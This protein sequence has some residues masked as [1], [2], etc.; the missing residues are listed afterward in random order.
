MWIL[1]IVILLGII[2][3]KLIVNA[4]INSYAKTLWEDKGFNE[5]K[6][7]AES[8]ARQRND[9]QERLMQCS[10]RAM[11][12]DNYLIQLQKAV[13]DCGDVREGI[14][15]HLLRKDLVLKYGVDWHTADEAVRVGLASGKMKLDPQAALRVF[16]PNEYAALQ[17]FLKVERS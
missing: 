14:A 9:A 15:L 3:R 1:V 13:N 7:N 12:E 17:G 16:T 8:I 5:L 2:F 10:H 11:K 6:D 4:M